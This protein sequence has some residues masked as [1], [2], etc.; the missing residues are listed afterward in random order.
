[1]CSSP[2]FSFSKTTV[3]FSVPTVIVLYEVTLAPKELIIEQEEAHLVSI[4]LFVTLKYRLRFCILY[5]FE[6]HERSVDW[7]VD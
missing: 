4:R 1:M 6:Q 2:L 5:S 3:W 7:K